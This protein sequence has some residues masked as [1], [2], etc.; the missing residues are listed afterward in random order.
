MLGASERQDDGRSSR[1]AQHS[2]LVSAGDIIFRSA[3]P[4]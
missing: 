3:V 2:M 4:E 1:M